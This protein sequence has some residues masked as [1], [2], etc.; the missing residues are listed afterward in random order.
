[1]DS[2][3]G[4]MKVKAAVEEWLSA[5]GHELEFEGN[6]IERPIC[7]MNHAGGYGKCPKI[8]ISRNI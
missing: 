2:I 1:M 8:S 4:P 3:A 5:M 6:G 7:E